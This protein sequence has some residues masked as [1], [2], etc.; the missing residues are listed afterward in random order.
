MKLVF[1]SSVMASESFFFSNPSKSSR[2]ASAFFHFSR[3]DR[4]Y[5]SSSTLLLITTLTLFGAVRSKS[6]RG[7]E[8]F[9]CL[10]NPLDA[11]ADGVDHLQA[12]HSLRLERI[13]VNT[14]RSIPA[15][16]AFDI[17]RHELASVYDNEAILM[18]DYID[19]S[20]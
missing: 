15:N 3:N 2:F 8:R 20:A 18:L 10:K 7:K 13:A 14:E 6:G 5:R 1:W 11:A 19:S 4:V 9:L 12:Y 16:H 17:A